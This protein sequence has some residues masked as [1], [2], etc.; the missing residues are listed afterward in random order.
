MGGAPGKGLSKLFR[1]IFSF[2]ANHARQL[3]R[4][5]TI[6]AL[7]SSVSNNLRVE[8]MPGPKRG[9]PTCLARSGPEAHSV[10]ATGSSAQIFPA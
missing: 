9:V 3:R 5:R 8:H 6:S 4:E 1:D 2:R 7:G 10:G